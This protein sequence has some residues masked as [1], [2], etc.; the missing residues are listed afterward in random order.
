MSTASYR[1]GEMV[2]TAV[3]E[4]M[5]AL[6]HKPASAPVFVS[7]TLSKTIPKT[8]ITSGEYEALCAVPAMVRLNGI[9]LHD[10]YE[11]N[12]QECKPAKKPRKKPQAPK[13]TAES[14]AKASDSVS[15]SPK[16]GSLDQLIA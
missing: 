4:C 14:K 16:L 2:G 5:R 1:F 9:N 13:Q 8:A 11:A 6:N 15:A 3:R 7:A 12:M 10:W